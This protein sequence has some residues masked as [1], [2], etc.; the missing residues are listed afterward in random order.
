MVEIVRVFKPPVRNIMKS[1]SSTQKKN[2]D[3]VV[4][5]EA[6]KE[7][8]KVLNELIAP[9][10][11]KANVKMN[12]AFGALVEDIA[13]SLAVPGV[14]EAYRWSSAFSVKR[15]AAAKPFEIVTPAF[16]QATGNYPQLGLSEAVGILFRNPLRTTIIYD[17]NPSVVTKTYGVYM[18]GGAGASPATA[19]SFILNVGDRRY[20]TTPYAVSTGST[21]SPHGPVLYAGACTGSNGRFL[22]CDKGDTYVINAT[23][24]FTAQLTVGVDYFGSQGL[25]TSYKETV[26]TFTSGTP[27]NITLKDVTDGAG[28][29]SVYLIDSGL[30]SNITLTINS[31]T[32][33]GNGSS[34]GHRAL[35]GFGTNFAAQL[36]TRILGQS[37]M[38]TNTAP[39]L[40]LGGTVCGFQAGDSEHW[41]DYISTTSTFSQCSK[42]ADS[43]SMNASKGMYGFM[44]PIQ[45][46]DFEFQNYVDLDSS[47]AIEDCYY[48]IDDVK[49][50]LVVVLTIPV[51][52]GCAGYFTS[53]YSIEY[54]TEDTWRET[55][56]STVP[57]QA[58]SEALN[59]L[60]RIDQ[61]H[62]NPLHWSDIWNG[63]KKAVSTVARA[64]TT[65]GPMAMNIAKTVGALV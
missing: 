48:P 43:V 7:T 47:G 32:I 31:L 44:K 40:N 50:F 59:L 42:V 12:S 25:V 58:Y 34:L 64:V 49:S 24:N 19:Q 35:P 23:L 27:A 52:A 9:K 54:L 57:E 38:F 28:Y 56:Y 10:V 39:M 33:S 3:K 53:R 1:N 41:L 51:A 2:N 13:L 63:I 6:K 55:E 16:G 20:V 14:R 8:K 30:S 4:K 60:R 21:F 15:T 11:S 45:P 37:L 17:Q 5:K 36:G 62:E 18:R 29:Y 61:F 65:Y 26:Q 22:W 46:S